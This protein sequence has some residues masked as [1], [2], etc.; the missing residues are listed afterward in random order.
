[1]G[2][3]RTITTAQ[4]LEHAFADKS[5]GGAGVDIV[6]L[7]EAHW[8]HAPNMI[9]ARNGPLLKR[10]DSVVLFELPLL[11]N[12]DLQQ[13]FIG[14]ISDEA[15]LAIFEKNTKNEPLH[16]LIMEKAKTI[17]ELHHHGVPAFSIDSR[18]ILPS[19]LAVSKEANFVN[20]SPE[21]RTGWEA[22]GMDKVLDIVRRGQELKLPTDVITAEIAHHF[23]QGHT[24]ALLI[25]GEGHMTRRFNCIDDKGQ[26]RL[27]KDAIHGVV[28]DALK[29]KGYNVFTMPLR[30][31][32]MSE[33]KGTLL[34]SVARTVYTLSL[35]SQENRSCTSDIPDARARLVSGSDEMNIQLTSEQILSGKGAFFKGFAVDASNSSEPASPG[36]TPSPRAVLG[37][38]LDGL[39]TRK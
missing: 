28:D 5:A 31:S 39:G 3:P 19:E 38:K 25:Y 24:K 23:M 9:A 7:G 2:E 32:W 36:Q 34:D 6:A 20:R 17:I 29:A 16:A 27:D 26:V 37:D 21:Y 14:A 33:V 15:L 4:F 22:T 8:D 12:P 10:V 35:N 13:H 11:S 18:V 1:M 30:T